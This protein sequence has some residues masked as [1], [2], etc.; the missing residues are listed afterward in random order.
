MLLTIAPK[1]IFGLSAFLDLSTAVD[2][3]WANDSIFSAL[4]FIFV[5]GISSFVLFSLVLV[6][7]P[8]PLEGHD[9]QN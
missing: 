8:L 1:S 7:D 6:T 4:V 2:V 3:N 5:L 9:R